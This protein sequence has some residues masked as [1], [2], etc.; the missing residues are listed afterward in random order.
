MTDAGR[1]SG[2]IDSFGPK[3]CLSEAAKRSRGVVPAQLIGT[4][5]SLRLT[6]SA[7]NPLANTVCECEAND[8]SDCNFK[9]KRFPA[10]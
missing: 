9:H 3:L 6:P 10:G 4:S 1:S 2:P 5:L 8:Q 7:E